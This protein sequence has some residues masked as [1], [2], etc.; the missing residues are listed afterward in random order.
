V[1]R[2][3]PKIPNVVGETLT[4]AKRA[5]EEGRLRRRQGDAT[6]V[7]PAEADRTVAVAAAGVSALGT[8]GQSRDRKPEPAP[9]INCTPGYS[10]CLIYHGGAD[11]DC[12]GGSDEGL[13]TGRVRVTGSDPYDLD[14]ATRV[15]L[16][17][18]G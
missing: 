12:A 10:P 16:R 15:P 9:T 1:A 13:Y 8:N 11:Y 3:P 2:A 4:K 14:S 18:E 5:P 7:E 17:V 6:D